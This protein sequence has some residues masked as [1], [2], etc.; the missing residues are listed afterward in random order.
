M[1]AKGPQEQY[2]DEMNRKFGYMATW[3]PGTPLKLGDIGVIHDNVFSRVAGLEDF[4]ITF[5]IREDDTPE[6]LEYSSKGSVSVTTKLSGAVT[7]PG[8]SLG[9]LDAGFIVEFSGQNS[10]LFKANKTKTN[11]IK[12]TIKIGEE[13]LKLYK[14]GK[15]NKKWVVITELVEAETATILISNAKNARIELK[16]NANIKLPKLD[17][18]EASLDL[19][20]TSYKGMDTK[21]ISQSGLSPLFKVK[22]IRTNIFLPPAFADKGLKAFD[23]V[24]P[25]T[26]A[27]EYKDNLYFDYVSSDEWE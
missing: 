14:D 13:V 1:L 6:D 8:S 17:I 23:F 25:A 21:I 20:Y 12:N 18:A 9:N 15:W 7:P 2:T 24:T 3:L 16:A 22:G 5:Y 26:A 10:I 19:G 4:D 27:G 11:L